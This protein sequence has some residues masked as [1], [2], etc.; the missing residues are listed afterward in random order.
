MDNFDHYYVWLG[1]APEE[2]P[3]NHYRLLGIRS[4]EENLQVIANAA[5]RQMAH[6]RTFQCGPQSAV[7]QQL[8]NEI[9][10]A[11]LTLLKP[12]RKAQYD[13]ALRETLQQAA[14]VPGGLITSHRLDLPDDISRVKKGKDGWSMTSIGILVAAFC[15]VLL[16]VYWFG[17]RS[18]NDSPAVPTRPAAKNKGQSEQAKRDGKDRR[19]GFGDRKDGLQRNKRL[20]D[21]TDR[22]KSEASPRINGLDRDQ[23]APDSPKEMPDNIA[24]NP[25]PTGGKSE[26]EQESIGDDNRFG[27]P[28]PS[29]LGGL[30][31]DNPKPPPSAVNVP[32]NPAVPPNDESI[33][34]KKRGLLA[35]LESPDPH[36]RSEAALELGKLRVIEDEVLDSIL[37]LLDDVDP[38]VRDSA[39]MTFGLLG[40]GA[41]VVVPKL[42][43]HYKKDVAVRRTIVDVMII[44]GSE[45]DEAVRFLVDL[46]RGMP[47]GTTRPLDFGLA[48]ARM[49]ACQALGRL[50]THGRLGVPVLMDIAKFAAVDLQQYAHFFN[51]AID[52]LGMIG[53]RRCLSLLDS[54]RDGKGLKG[55]AGLVQ[56]A[57]TRA[58]S[59]YRN[60]KDALE[61][62]TSK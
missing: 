49:A 6:V 34:A 44:M 33:E 7:S 13:H 35:K 47:S 5:D 18:Q 30:G 19:T 4:F 36:Q 29:E 55:Q 15:I 24:T 53:D 22:R 37:K 60:I 38:A 9:S 61:A 2:Q 54:Y 39:V 40:S 50:G 1:I 32:Q 59:A 11:R 41:A 25:P 28:K 56:A 8:L 23:N 3:P 48:E 16:P 57:A 42:T 45:S 21:N 43:K 52:S 62:A 17:V 10:A 46:V 14:V 51:A 27:L 31:R 58:D 26:S 12:D 20:P